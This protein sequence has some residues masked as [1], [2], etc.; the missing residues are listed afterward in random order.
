MKTLSIAEFKELISR[1]DWQHEQSMVVED[2]DYRQHPEYDEPTGKQNMVDIFHIWGWARKISRLDDIT[3]VVAE[4]Y[5]YDEHDVDS[6]KTVEPEYDQFSVEGLIVLYEDGEQLQA[7]EI[8]DYL[9]D[10]C[11]SFDYS[12]LLKKI[13]HDANLANNAEPPGNNHIA[14]P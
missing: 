6:F 14:Q 4:G 11:T 2:A 13:E 10:A 5:S 1:N 8:F 12:D 9:P 3:F 7:S